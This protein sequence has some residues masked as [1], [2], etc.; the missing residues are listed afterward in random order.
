MNGHVRK[1][2]QTWT[3]YFDIG[4]VNGK[5]KQKSKGGFRTKADA[6][7]A[8]RKRLEEY[9]STGQ[10]FE[11]EKISISDFIEYWL[12]TYIK[13][14]KKISTHE[15]YARDC[16]VHIAPVLGS[17]YI[18]NVSSK[19][20]QDFLVSKADTHAITTVA[21]LYGELSSLFNYALSLGYLKENPLKKVSMPKKKYK[22]DVTVLTIEQINLILD[23]LKNTNL[24]PP[25][26]IALH[27]GMRAGEV[28][29]LTWS[30][31]DIEN[32][33][34]RVDKQLQYLQKKWVLT[35]PKTESSNRNIKINNLLKKYL[36]DLKEK[37][38]GNKDFY[39]EYYLTNKV[40][41]IR[42]T[43][44]KILDGVD[45]VNVR[46]NG[47]MLTTNSLKY[48]SRVVNRELGIN[49]KFHYLRHTHATLLLENGVNAKV[50]Q[51]RLGHS[52][53]STTLD[54]Y[55]HVTENMQQD[56]ADKLDGALSNLSTM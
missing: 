34:I 7:R 33:V 38:D 32:S 56:A 30:S 3:Y 4:K 9:Q 37:Q 10:V 29:G 27:T 16:R 23:R 35:T 42:F 46:E 44:P 12:S 19:M 54:T 26:M 51:E 20:I 1:R 25:I 22:K 24:I 2:G 11:P 31:V 36:I 43:N 47:E 13:I 8:L 18:Q 15:H 53:I 45:F 21:N 52:K 5:R 39:G 49:F 55:S 50:A 17:Y 48:I 14:N 41:D 28:M 40:V 6:Q